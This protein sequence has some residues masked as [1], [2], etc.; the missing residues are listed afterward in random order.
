MDDFKE[1][2][3]TGWFKRKVHG[4]KMS[5]SNKCESGM[6]NQSFTWL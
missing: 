4:N 6:F 2:I 1:E 5:V 3:P